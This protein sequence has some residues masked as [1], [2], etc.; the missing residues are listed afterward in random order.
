[1]GKAERERE[2]G[3]K[4]YKAYLNTFEKQGRIV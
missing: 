2:R 4:D 1:M 3:D